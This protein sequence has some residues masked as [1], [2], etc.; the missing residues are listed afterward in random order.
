M[1]RSIL[2]G[3]MWAGDGLL[4]DT[5]ISLNRIKLDGQTYLQAI[6]R[7]ITEQKKVQSEI[8]RN[9][10]L[11]IQLFNNIPAGIAI[12]D[13]ENK[14]QMTNEGF[15]NIFGYLESELKGKDIDSLILPD[16]CQLEGP[17]LSQVTQS[18]D[19][20][21]IETVR[22][23]KDG[24]LIPVM[25]E[26]VSVTIEN[27]PIAIFGIYIDIRE[28]YENEKKV[29]DALKEKETLLAEI[30][31]RVKNNLAVISGLLELQLGSS[32]DQI[33]KEVLQE[34][35]TRIQSIALIHEKLYHSDTLSNIA[36]DD[37]VRDLI[38]T[39]R[40]TYTKTSCEI[41]FDIVTDRVFLN[42]N[43]AIPCALILNELIVNIYK[44]AFHGYSRGNVKVE[45]HKEQNNINLSVK[46]NGC[47]L[48]GDFNFQKPRSLGMKL[49]QTLSRQL[50][51][52]PGFFKEN[53]TLFK[54]QFDSEK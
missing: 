39:I 46:D 34:S 36:F 44:H 2:S 19:T 53:G 22:K 9:T 43:Q 13:L 18:G 12:V 7:D 49:I 50:G 10:E 54:L 38:K 51:G 1:N 31:H 3:K 21:Q 30:H 28:R 32:R 40:H 8:I 24:T 17:V 4:I 29:R 16:D 25:F 35:Q 48:P 6:F 27:K 20:F 42:I 26:G 33:V 47:G 45:L 14:I 5:Y 23:H 15:R 52:E 41:S 11:F 37:Y